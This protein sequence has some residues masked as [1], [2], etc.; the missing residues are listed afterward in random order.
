[1]NKNNHRFIVVKSIG[2]VLLYLIIFIALYL[3]YGSGDTHND[4][5]Y[6]EF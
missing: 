1:M 3:L 6:N 2:L 5:I 4:F